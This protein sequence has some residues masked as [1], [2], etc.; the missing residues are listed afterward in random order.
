MSGPTLS[1]TD[2]V[3]AAY[4]P[5]FPGFVVLWSKQ[6]KESRYFS[7]DELDRLEA[8]VSRLFPTEDLY[9][10]LGT[11]AARL[12]H[13]Q[14]GGADGVVALP[15]FFADID[16]ATAKG[17]SRSYPHDGEEARSI[18]G[19]FPLVPTLLVDTGNGLHAHWLLSELH[20]IQNEA[21]RL[22]ARAVWTGFQRALI[23][24]FKIHGRRIDSVG[25]LARNYRI[26][27]TLNHKTEPPKP[28]VIIQH[29]PDRRY[30]LSEIRKLAQPLMDAVFDKKASRADHQRHRPADHATIMAGCAW[31]REEV[32]DGA[33]TCDEPN[34]YAGASITARCENGPAVFHEY[35]A[36]HPR[37]NRAE[38]E[39]KLSRARSEAG[40]RTCRSIEY[41]LGHDACADCPFR[42][43]IASPIQIGRRSA[44]FG[45]YEPGERGPIPLGHA[46]SDFVFRHQQTQEVVRK[47]AGQLTSPAGLL[48]LAPKEF[49]ETAYPRL[50]PKGAVTGIDTIAAANGLI[51]ASR[52]AGFMDLIRIRGIGVW[53]ESDR[54][55]VNLGGE[56]I[57][58]TEFVYSAPPKRLVVSEG[59]VPV[60]DILRFFSL[61]NWSTP[62]APEL[63]LGACVTAVICGALA[64][65]PHVGIT[66][67]SQS[68]K[69]TVMSAIGQ[70]LTPMAL[71]VEGVSTEAG[72]RQQ[73]GHDARPV[74]IDEFEV[75]GTSDL[76][77]IH[78]LTKL[79]RSSSSATGEVLRGTQDGRGQVFVIR[80]MFIVAAI[81]LLGRASAADASRLVRLEMRRPES[82][83]ETGEFIR[84]Q[85]RALERLGPAFVSRAIALAKPILD[86]IPKVHRALVVTQERQADN[87]AT[88]VAAFGVLVAGRELTDGEAAA[89]AE[90]F[91]PA[92]AA[93]AEDANTDDAAECLNALLGHT[94]TVNMGNQPERW[95]VGRLIATVSGGDHHTKAEMESA[96]NQ[97][98]LKLEGNGFIVARSHPG[99]RSVFGGTRW[100]SGMWGSALE[101]LEGAERTPLRRFADGVRSRGVFVPA[102]YLPPASEASDQ[103][104]NNAGF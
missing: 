102:T 22:D 18:L 7:A 50:G 56:E 99:L 95:S 4:G 37:Y 77:R 43:K 90:R 88:L 72:I 14:R 42:E 67:P 63:L 44:M 86:S 27:G 33:A 98:G 38:A 32:V 24:H 10:A 11:Q 69:S 36:K 31:Y 74:V 49:W 23:A 25:D 34:W 64:W 45:P 39:E 6:S 3:S 20:V 89:L 15:C 96:L 19:T 85:R 79:I 21:A 51:Q 17:S 61:P 2:L 28:V 12:A 54:L 60:E 80:A 26:P 68:G 9:L 87:I 101:R 8:A 65:R 81:N 55:V 16:F 82:P 52:Q 97:L 91:A 47:T 83:R 75:E 84:S 100:D 48:E 62:G 35:S 46:G 40:P 13:T 93:Q 104:A 59:D 78:R 103:R 71:V 58:S 76:N 92:I 94:V 29:H 5:A 41:D 73:L 53:A 66:G 70:L 57:V 30:A 1:V